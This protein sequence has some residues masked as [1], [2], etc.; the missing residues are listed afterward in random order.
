MCLFYRK[1]FISL[2]GLAEKI[3]LTHFFLVRVGSPYSF[4]DSEI[5]ELVRKSKPVHQVL[6]RPYRFNS[7]SLL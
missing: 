7:G 1:D 3:T 6:T 4:G 5:A 2:P